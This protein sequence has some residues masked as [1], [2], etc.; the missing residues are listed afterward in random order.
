LSVFE[1]LLIKFEKK[2]PST[3]IKQLLVDLDVVQNPEPYLEK[4]LLEDGVNQFQKEFLIEHGIYLT[5]D[6]AAKIKLLEKS[7][8]ENKKVRVLCNELFGDY[9]HG[10]RLMKLE[11]FNIPGEAVD[12]PKAFLDA[13]IKKNYRQ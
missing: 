1:K 6:D 13:Y 5:I 7:K 11:N 12:D 2:L 10:I 8:S 9:F 4:L 3:G